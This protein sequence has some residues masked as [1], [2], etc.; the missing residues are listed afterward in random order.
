MPMRVGIGRCGATR[1]G[2]CDN[3]NV[4]FTLSHV[5]AALP[6]RRSRLILSA[7]IVGAMAPDLEYFV[8]LAPGGGWG[9]TIA[10]AFGLSLP[11]G[12][13]VLWLF[14]RFAKA[15]ILALLP[16]SLQCRVGSA[17][18]RPF[19]F[20]GLRRFLWIVLSLLAGIATHLAW[21]SFTHRRTWLYLHWNLL[22]EHVPLPLLHR[23][24]V[25]TFLQLIS[26]I[27]GLAIVLYWIVDWYRNTPPSRRP[28]RTIIS[29]AQKTLIVTLM[30]AISV[31][32]G[33]LRGLMRTGFLHKHRMAYAVTFAGDAVVTMGALLW[34]Q[35]VAWGVLMGRGI[36]RPVS[37]SEPTLR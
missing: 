11:L 23:M 5:A 3:G 9:H 37:E 14:H 22:R 17:A 16:V 29:P 2:H 6:M 21:D 19:P 20:H 8:R 31:A 30:I 24:H 7:V 33:V 10:G 15:P 25:Y 28:L 35:L 32:G 36:I 4:P 13:A 26:S 18:L 34:W 12:L 27:A 1:M